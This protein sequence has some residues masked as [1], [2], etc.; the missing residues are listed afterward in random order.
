MSHWSSFLSWGKLLSVTVAL[1]AC[2]DSP[3]KNE[4][5][6]SVSATEPAILDSYTSKSVAVHGKTVS[7]PNELQSPRD[8]VVSGGVLWV[9]ENVGMTKTVHALSPAGTIERT[10]RP[11]DTTL[12]EG[13]WTL[14]PPRKSE[15]GVWVFDAEKRRMLL[16]APDSS[17]I[18]QLRV[19]REIRLQDSVFLTNPK[20]RDQSTLVTPG[21]FPSGRVA[22]FDSTGR[23][24][25]ILGATPGK[26]T[27]FPPEIIQHAYQSTLAP[28]PSDSRFVLATRYADQIEIFSKDSERPTLGQRPFRFDPYVTVS[29]TR[30]GRPFAN[31]GRARFGYVDVVADDQ[32]ILGLFSGKLSQRFHGRENYGRYIH[33]FD[34]SGNLRRV[35]QLDEDAIAL[36]LNAS[37]RKVYALGGPPDPTIREYSLIDVVGSGIKNR[38][39]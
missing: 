7:L 32:R 22:Q 39:K 28:R 35:V 15:N 27:A 24:I 36:A 33:V 17:N 31:L 25:H 12:L 38:A 16:I 1:A 29:K 9:L 21:F 2:K 4:S 10:L 23:L 26:A 13:A 37:A 5:S 11:S 3:R 34:W 14:A 18:R 19:Q 8:I 20:W 6:V 30:S